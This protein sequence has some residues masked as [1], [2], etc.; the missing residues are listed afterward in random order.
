MLSPVLHPP[1]HWQPHR[2]LLQ[3]RRGG[4]RGVRPGLRALGQGGHQVSR[5]TGLDSA[6]AVFLGLFLE[7]TY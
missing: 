1:G 2:G 4:R 3:P 6:L 7:C 5:S